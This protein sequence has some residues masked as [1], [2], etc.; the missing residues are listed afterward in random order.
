MRARKG[1]TKSPRSLVGEGVRTGE[2]YFSSA[3][4]RF[5]LDRGVAIGSWGSDLML[6]NWDDGS[7]R[8]QYVDPQIAAEADAAAPGTPIF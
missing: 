6:A 3:H 7:A 2:A 1:Q 8:R 4:S 5:A